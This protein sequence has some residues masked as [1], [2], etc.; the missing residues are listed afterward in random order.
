MSC[1][2][3]E[4]KWNYGQDSSYLGKELLKKQIITQRICIFYIGDDLCFES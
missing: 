1:R 4:K 3:H 2:A